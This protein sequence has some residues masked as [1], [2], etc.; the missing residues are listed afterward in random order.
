MAHNLLHPEVVFVLIFAAV[1]VCLFV[2]L[3]ICFCSRFSPHGIHP[4]SLPR[5]NLPQLNRRKGGPESEHG[6]S[7]EI[8]ISLE[9]QTVLQ[10]WRKHGQVWQKRVKRGCQC[11]CEGALRKSRTRRGQS[12]APKPERHRAHHSDIQRVQCCPR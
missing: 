3:L 1:F 6:C 4:V 7:S 9:P 11:R 5:I 8:I 10:T 12:P 2:S